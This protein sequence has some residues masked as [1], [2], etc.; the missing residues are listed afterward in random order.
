[1]KRKKPS[2]APVVSAGSKLADQLLAAPAALLN[3]KQEKQKAV[4]RKA[5]E[6]AEQKRLEASKSTEI[7]SVE[8]LIK[9]LV[10]VAEDPVTN[11]VWHKFRSI[12]R[13]RYEL[14]GFYPVRF[15]DR[16]FGTFAHAKE[17]AGLTDEEGTRLWRAARAKQSREEHAQR[18][19]ERYLQP[20]TVSQRANR[21]LHEPY[22]LLSISDTHA[23][24][25]DPFVWACFIQAIRDLK[26]NGVLL[27]GDILDGGE[28]SSHPQI[29]GRSLKLKDELAFQRTM[30]RQIRSVHDGDLFSTCG[31]HDLASRLPR[32]L[33]QVD[34]V[35]SEIDDRRVDELM[36][37]REFDVQLFH[38]GSVKSPRGTEDAVPGFLMFGFYRIHHGTKLG[39]VPSASELRS[40][41]RSGQSGHVHRASLFYGTT[42]PTEGMSWMST[43]MGAR[44]E[45]GH[46]IASPC[47]GWQRGFGVAWLYPS[48][49]AHQYPVVVQGKPERMVVEGHT[50]ER[51]SSLVDPNPITSGNWLEKM[52]P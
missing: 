27:N 19:F 3:S 46:Y 8:D 33:S 40:M 45:V 34:S 48:G 5:R 51:N 41:G 13:R 18:Y 7:P 43:P 25:L 49:V 17:V 2:P 24:F 38:G 10:R 42:E 28:L 31:N 37:L 26:P 21:D 35:I 6:L 29:R 4:E 12:S 32:Y 20:Y 16:Q 36:G 44:H 30:F 39:E 47:T 50:Y 11:P 52:K 1:M 22:L 14:F 23:H 9:D 15:V